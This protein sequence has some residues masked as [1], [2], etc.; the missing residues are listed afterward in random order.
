MRSVFACSWDA[1]S[2][3]SSR[4]RSSSRRA[5]GSR[6]PPAIPEPPVDCE[7]GRPEVDKNT[8]R[9]CGREMEPAG[10]PPPLVFAA[11]TESSTI[12]FK[13][14]TSACS[15]RMSLSSLLPFSITAINLA[16]KSLFAC[17]RVLLLACSASTVI[18]LETASSRNLTSSAS[19]SSSAIFL[20]ASWRVAGTRG[21][22]SF[23]LADPGG[24]VAACFSAAISSSLRCNSWFLLLRI[25]ICCARPFHP[26]D[27]LIAFATFV[28]GSPPSS[29][30]NARVS[31][32]TSPR[33]AID[34]AFSSSS[35]RV[36]T[37]SLSLST[38]ISAS[39]CWHDAGSGGGCAARAAS[40][41]AMREFWRDTADFSF[42]R[43]TVSRRAFF[44]RSRRAVR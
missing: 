13:C 8:G 4:S 2:R 38:L 20:C 31:R 19:R 23:A 33:R 41:S 25:A 10:W 40:S 27:S 35:L 30:D 28:L 5:D 29:A 17:A 18:C 14:A 21:C 37:E 3:R 36:T 42:S 9:A 32:D 22:V 39:C 6:S 1:C 12:F 44:A 43:A 24:A 7:F 16:F 15:A 11:D 34:V 26:D